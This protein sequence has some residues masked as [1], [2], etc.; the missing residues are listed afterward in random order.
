MLTFWLYNFWVTVTVIP[1][2]A[3]QFNSQGAHSLRSKM[4]K[5][6]FD[7]FYLFSASAC[8]KNPKE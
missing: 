6:N 3:L 4:R 7:F 2:L 5:L 1:A 8:G